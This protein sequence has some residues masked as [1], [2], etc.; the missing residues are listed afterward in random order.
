MNNSNYEYYTVLT[1][2]KHT[3]KVYLR[4]NYGT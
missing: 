1:Q 2:N 3:I 4:L